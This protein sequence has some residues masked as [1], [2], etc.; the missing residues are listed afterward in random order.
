MNVEKIDNLSFFAH[1]NDG[2][3]KH[4]FADY[5]VSSF[6]ELL[7]NG[8]TET[9]TKPKDWL[10][11]EQDLRYS[12]MFN[13][14]YSDADPKGLNMFMVTLINGKAGH[15][16]ENALLFAFNNLS[17]VWTQQEKDSIN[18]ILERNNFVTRI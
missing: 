1:T 10:S 12:A 17:V 8:H 18:Q 3:K 7:L 14:A 15:A 9:N 2:I 5:G 11:L 13:K 16:T 6:E 4:Y